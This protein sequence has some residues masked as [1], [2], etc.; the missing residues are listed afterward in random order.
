MTRRKSRISSETLAILQQMLRENQRAYIG[1]NETL[2]SREKL[3]Q[4]IIEDKIKAL[5]ETL[6]ALGTGSDSP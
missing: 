2:T 3:S 5:E 4:M 1:P 6:E